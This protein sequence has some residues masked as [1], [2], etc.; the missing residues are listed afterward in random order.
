MTMIEAALRY[1]ARG[2][3]VFP[4]PPGT[5][6]SHKSETHS[7]G[8]KWGMTRDAEEIRRDFTQWPNAGIGLPTGAVNKIIVV[9]TD[10]VTGHGVDGDA[11]LRAI[12]AKYG[13]LPITLEAI[14]PSG[15]IHRYFRHPRDGIRIKNSASEIAAGIDVRGDGGMVVAPPSVRSDGAYRW[16]NRKRIAPMPAWLV[17]LTKDKPPTI[18][19]RAAVRVPI[20]HCPAYGMAA[21]KGEIAA[22]CNAPDGQRNHALN[23]A[24]FNLHQLVAVGQLNG[25]D[26]ER[27]LITACE[28]NGLMADR[29]NGGPAGVIA[30][31]KS[32]AR[33]GLQNPRG[34]R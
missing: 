7:N 18:S 32:G 12:E 17:E 33:A 27:E 15:S 6:K 25:P 29:K 8:R 24:S 10:T 4:V 30:T 26:V 21:L 11:A 5:K 1:A 22:L 31:I 3:A 13:P 23:T 16:L 9:E 28:I 20:S 2:L 34:R 14:S 19:Q